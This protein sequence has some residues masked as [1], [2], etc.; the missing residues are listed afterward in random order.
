MISAEIHTS[1][2]I[3]KASLYDD[4]AP[5]TVENFVTLAK[6]GFYEG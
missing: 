4:D 2:G 1:K 6:K 3:M 5:A